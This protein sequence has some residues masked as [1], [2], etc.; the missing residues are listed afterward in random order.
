MTTHT[1]KEVAAA[2]KVSTWQVRV[3]IRLGELPASRI[4]VAKGKRGSVRVEDS[5]LVRFM[6][7]RRIVAGAEKQTRRR[8][9]KVLE[10]V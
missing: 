1:V 9:G 7:Q 4:G 2:L 3:L 8:V 5:D 10:V 6:A